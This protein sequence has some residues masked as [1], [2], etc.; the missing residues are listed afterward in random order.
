MYIMY[1][2]FNK[3]MRNATMTSENASSHILTFSHIC[4]HNIIPGSDN[5]GYNLQVYVIAD[6]IC[7]L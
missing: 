5:L 4:H 1:K 2:S 6:I 3:Y 7:N